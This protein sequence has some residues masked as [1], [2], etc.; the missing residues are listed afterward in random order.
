MGYWEHR[1]WPAQNG[2]QICLSR[3][4][5]LGIDQLGSQPH[6]ARPN[7]VKF[8][9]IRSVE[10]GRADCVAEYDYRGREMILWGSVMLGQ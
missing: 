7:P 4:K 8:E 2:R 3:S 9:H 5:Y 6:P 10:Q 1:I